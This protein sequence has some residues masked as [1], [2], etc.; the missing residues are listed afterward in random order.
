[1]NSIKRT[2]KYDVC[3]KMYMCKKLDI[4]EHFWAIELVVFDLHY[5]SS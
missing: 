5:A 1:M 2:P 3:I 4:C